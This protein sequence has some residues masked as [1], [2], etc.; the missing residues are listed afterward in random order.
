MAHCSAGGTVPIWGTYVGVA[1]GFISQPG[2]NIGQNIQADGLTSLPEELRLTSPWK[3]Q[4]WAVGLLMF[5]GFSLLNF[6][7]LSFAPASI[8]LPLE[9]IQFVSNVAYARVVHK[10][11]VPPQMSWGVA[12]ALVGTTCTVVFGSHEGSCYAVEDFEAPWEGSWSWWTY[13]V[14]SLTVSAACAAVW[15]QYTDEV[16]AGREPWMHKI[17]LPVT[18][19]LI[20]AMLGGSQLIVNSKVFSESL[21]LLT[22]GD[23]SVLRSWVPY[24]SLVLTVGCGIIWV[25]ALTACLSMYARGRATIRASL[26]VLLL[27]ACRV[28]S[29]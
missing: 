22:H 16:E 8:L 17:V 7:A 25:T 12:L 11:A 28:S 10:K 1:M 24:V 4:L 23:S 2:I 5:I 15:K 27:I 13:V 29:S 18:F 14:L 19:T 21:S 9:S 26:P 6:V 20:A 3:S